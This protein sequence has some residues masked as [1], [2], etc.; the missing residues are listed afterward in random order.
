MQRIGN[1]T[2]ASFK[3]TLAMLTMIRNMLLFM[4]PPIIGIVIWSSYGSLIREGKLHM[5]WAKKEDTR[6]PVKVAGL[7]ADGFWE[8]LGSYM[9]GQITTGKW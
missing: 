2:T 8:D 4:T 9:W 6:K 5:L 1:F 7:F 3:F